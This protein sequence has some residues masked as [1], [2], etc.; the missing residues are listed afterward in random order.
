MMSRL[1]W[2]LLIATILGLAAALWALGRAGWAE[3]FASATRTGLGGFA[4]LCGITILTFVLLGGAWQAAVPG[5]SWRRI[6]RFTWARA[7]RDAANDL[8]PFSQLGALVVGARTLIAGGIGQVEIYAAM[9]VDLTTEMA[10]QLIFTLFALWAFGMALAGPNHADRLLPVLWAGLGIATAIML[11]F[12]VLQR[13]AIRFAAFLATRLLP[14]AGLMADGVGAQL[15]LV[16]A[17]RGRVLLSFL[18]NLAAW[19]A[20]AFWSWYALHLMGTEASVWRAAALESAIFALRS[21][22][23]LVPAAIG[24]QEAGYALLA[25]LVGI[26]PAAAL[27][28][29]LVKRARD[30]VLGVPTLLAW[31]AG[32]ITSGR[33]SAR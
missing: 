29:S 4:L 9:I 33:R 11:A 28:L 15:T 26:D 27:A 21:A 25:P 6:G 7:T 2:P 10:A 20:T 12:L 5:V 31:Q 19:A 17:H 23:F 3:V 18:L 16:Y 22:A 30:V 13:P 8:L 32:E 14:N 24:V 1:R